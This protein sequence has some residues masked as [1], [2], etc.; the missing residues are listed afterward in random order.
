MAKKLGTL[1]SGIAKETK[2]LVA[3]KAQCKRDLEL[4]DAQPR[5]I[6]GDII[7]KPSVFCSNA[8]YL[9]HDKVA[10]M[11]GTLKI[12]RFWLQREEVEAQLQIVLR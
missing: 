1:K 12:H 6:E 2:E 8:I 4:L 10:K 3:H 5:T 11:L 9:Q 7:V